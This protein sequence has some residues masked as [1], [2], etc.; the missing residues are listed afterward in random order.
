MFSSGNPI[1]CD[2][3]LPE[4]S[5]LME[6]NHTRIY[7][8]SHCGP[9]SEQ[10][11]TSKPSRF[12]GYIPEESSTP[13]PPPSSVA[14]HI[15]ETQQQIASENNQ[16]S[17]LYVPPVVHR[18]VDHLEFRTA[19]L[20][21]RTLDERH[22][23]NLEP[24]DE[25]PSESQEIKFK[26]ANVTSSEPKTLS[27]DSQVT[28]LNVESRNISANVTSPEPV[29]NEQMQSD[30]P[31]R[32]LMDPIAQE[33]QLSKMASEIELLRSQI[34]QLAE[35]NRMLLNQQKQLNKS[36]VQAEQNGNL[37]NV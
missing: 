8:V 18:T 7:G 16:V 6:A 27:E 21:R 31:P 34:E 29:Q 24:E 36:E 22:H 32:V 19:D 4:I 1:L 9:L 11:V 20:N 15:Y 35:Q 26:R 3:A 28:T 23:V 33:R 25:S 17:P 30:Q 12:L 14:E 5:A 2:A 10:P 13:S 37:P